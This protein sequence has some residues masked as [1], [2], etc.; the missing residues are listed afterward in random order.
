MS[1]F[2]LRAKAAE[3]RQLSRVVIRIRPKAHDALVAVSAQTG[4]SQ[5]TIA[6]KAILYA[7]DHL[8]IVQRDEKENEEMQG[9]PRRRRLNRKEGGTG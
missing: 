7:M 6:T 8:R 3:E 2:I 1:D 4:I 5:A 9:T